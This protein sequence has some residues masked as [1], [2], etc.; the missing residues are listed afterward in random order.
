MQ[1]DQ[2]AA[3]P[4][5]IL[6]HYP[7][8][9]FAEK[10][11]A[12]LGFKGLAWRSVFVPSVMPKPELQ[13]LTGGYRR[14]PVL[15]IGADVYC[16]TSLIAQVLEHLQP[17]PPLFPVGSSGLARI[18]AQ[19]GDD[20]LFWAA[21]GYAL[22]PKGA[23]ALFAP[24]PGMDEAAAEQALQ[25]FAQDRAAMSAG[26]PRLRAGD[27]SGALR[28]YLRRLSDLLHGGQDWLLSSAA[29]TIADFACYH[30]LWF[31]QTQ[32]PPMAGVLDA[33]P[34]VQAWLAR[35]AVWSQRAAARAERFDAEGALAAARA[36]PPAELADAAGSFQDEHGIGLGSRVA[37]SAESFGT[38]ASTGVLVAASRTQL[39]IARDDPRAGRVHVHFPRIGYVLKRA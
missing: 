2:G 26:T 5:P 11:R 12:L 8:S 31:I 38:E 36:Q 39:T 3:A 4:L 37:I 6:H 28:S 27:A 9:P 1:S 17:E 29:P 10:A 18:V 35:M 33:V 34:R 23:A 21:M 19:W 14:V 20:K 25:A 22:Q 16:D 7:M 30:P 24:R 13:A 15:Q 32:V